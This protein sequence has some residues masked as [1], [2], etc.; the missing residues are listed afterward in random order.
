MSRFGIRKKLRG[1]LD[2]KSSEIIRHP[3]TYILPDGSSQVVHAEEGYDLL[4]ASQALPSPISTGRR[5]GGPCPDGGCGLCRVDVLD[6][7]GLSDQKDRERG[8][9]EA[10][11]RGDMHEGREREAG[12]PATE[13]TRLACH[14]RIQG[15]GGRVQ[16]PELFDYDSITG[17]PD[18]T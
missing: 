4:M 11:V 8:T 17:D 18:G 15:G 2:S 16:V 1:M 5:A 10:H 7:T 9:I 3:V 6:A 14:V 13:F 12:P